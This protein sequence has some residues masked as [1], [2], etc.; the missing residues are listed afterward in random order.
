MMLSRRLLS[1]KLHKILLILYDKI[2]FPG[3]GFSVRQLSFPGA[4]KLPCDTAS[5]AEHGR[6]GNIPVD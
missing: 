2:S 6:K 3:A 4:A 1:L 5:F